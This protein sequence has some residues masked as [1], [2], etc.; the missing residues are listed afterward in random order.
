M[1]RF[2]QSLIVSPLSDGQT[3]VLLKDFGYDVKEEGSGEVIDVPVGFKTDFA[4]VPRIFWAILPRWGRYGNA[5]V[6]HDY[7]YWS[8]TYSRKV[9]DQI[10]LEAMGVLGVPVI[11]KTFCMELFAGLDGAPG[12]GIAEKKLKTRTLNSK[13]I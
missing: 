6:I 4:S 10:F 13:K 11:Q 3:W 9:S 8:Q 2:T 7:C 1:S 5:A 12:A